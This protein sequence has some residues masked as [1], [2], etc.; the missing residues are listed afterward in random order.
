MSFLIIL[1]SIGLFLFAMQLISEGMQ[2]IAGD[3]LRHV[4]SAMTG[5]VFLGMLTG[6]GVTAV[7]QS[8]SAITVMA[9][10]FVN[11]GVITLAQ[12]IA[13]IMGANIGTTTTAWIIATLGFRFDVAMWAFPL[14]AIT[15]PF[16]R[17]R[18]S[19]ANSW[20]ELILGFALLFISL[21]AMKNSFDLI[22]GSWLSQQL[23]MPGIVGFTA[24][25]LLILVGTLFTVAVRSSSAAFALILLM[26]EAKWI[27]FTMG[28]CLLVFANIGTC[29]VPLIAA[30]KANAM[31]RRAALEHLLFNLFGMLWAL[32]T[33]PWF[34][35]LI[36]LCCQGL[37]LGNPYVAE[38]VPMGLAFF[39]TAFNLI[40]MVIL[41]PLTNIVVK[42]V[43]KLVP[44]KDDND[45]SFSLKYINNG[46][47][48]S[49]GEMALVQ[50]Q[51]EVSAFA[52][53][54]YKM[55]Q[56][57][58]SML[59]ESMGSARQ[60][61]MMQQVKILEEDSDKAELEI[62][63]FLNQISPQTLSMSGEQLCRNLYKVVDELES[64]ADCI[65]HCSTSL[66]QKSEQ[67][68]RFTS[69]QNN[70]IRKMMQLTD[71][72]L[73]HMVH[74]LSLDEVPPNALNRAYNY[75]DEINNFR[76]QMRNQMLDAMERREVEYQQHTHFMLLI[77]ECEKI[78][79]YVI[80]VISA[81][82]L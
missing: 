49:S 36:S 81:A 22:D 59:T 77:N 8:S 44:D 6:L 45:R 37:G 15:I 57:V 11:A 72:L 28:C 2:K 10:S 62:A 42:V 4:Q 23:S 21:E 19:T 55:F 52:D 26:S 16:F 9:V 71:S 7:V 5:N 51:K 61:E 69:Q 12:S 41:L 1:G 54:T 78:G 18:K 34:C 40:T 46:L 3:H 80:N 75:E 24:T 35:Q 38:G 32:A 82:S 43:T 70:D 58:N 74:V 53:D 67:L 31:A 39:H 25:A 14:I 73:L 47:M 64:I 13:V 27:T 79:D 20:G 17:S 60:L 65:Y 48:P 29:I 56:L 50:V 68:T 30:R 66:Y 63:Q 33:L 76:N